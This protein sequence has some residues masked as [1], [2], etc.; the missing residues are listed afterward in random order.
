MAMDVGSHSTLIAMSNLGELSN[1]EQNPDR[2]ESL[3]RRVLEGARRI[4]PPGHWFVGV[5]L[6]RYGVSLTLQ[7]KYPE[8]EDCLLE[9]YDLLSQALGTEN[10]RT[11]TTI[12]E[13]VRLYENWGRVDEK[14][15]W[16]KKTKLSGQESSSR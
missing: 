3:N 12:R 10:V 6:R 2:G 15:S 14:L 5:A 7:K 16:E 9:S 1:Q 8:A 13:L 11:Q 4:F